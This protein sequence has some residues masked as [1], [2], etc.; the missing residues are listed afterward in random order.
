[1]SKFNGFSI[2]LIEEVGGD[3][4]AHFIE[5]PQSV[6]IP[7][8][9]GNKFLSNTTGVQPKNVGNKVILIEIN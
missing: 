1:M 4:L 5:L 3:W 9:M 2:K 8:K 6:K 7:H